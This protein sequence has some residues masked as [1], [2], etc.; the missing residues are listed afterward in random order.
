MKNETKRQTSSKL[1]SPGSTTHFSFF[2][3]FI[4]LPPAVMMFHV[5]L[6]FKSDTPTSV[7]H[8]PYSSN[9]AP[10]PLSTTPPTVQ[11]WHPYLCPPHPLQFKS[12]T[13]TSVHH[14]PYPTVQIWHPYLCP[15]HP[16]QF[17]S[18]TPTSVHHTPY[19]SNLAPLPLF[20][21]T[22]LFL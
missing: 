13:P 17:K 1:T 15:P 21:T 4:Q 3:A 12:D 7:H 14:S 2:I 18:D 19:S 6:E 11:I 20:T 9:L 8:T 10:L 22:C 16:L 5:V